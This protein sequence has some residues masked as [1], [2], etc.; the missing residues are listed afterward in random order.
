MYSAVISSISP[1][2]VV[3]FVCVACACVLAFN[4]CTPRVDVRPLGSL[5]MPDPG[6]CYVLVYELPGF[7]GAREFINGPRKYPRLSDLPFRSNWRRRIQ[8][9]EVGGAAS[10]VLWTGEGFQGTS[11][12]WTPGSSHPTLPEGLTRRAEALDITC[13]PEGSLNVQ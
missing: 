3:W 7:M 6:G 8:S 9:A 11:Q 12:R 13:L 10:I 1:G 5:T 2:R 4:A